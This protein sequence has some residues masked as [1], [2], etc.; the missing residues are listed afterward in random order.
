MPDKT[1]KK[2]SITIF[3]SPSCRL[4]GA[5]FLIMLAAKCFGFYPD[6]SWWIVTCPL[7]ITFAICGAFFVFFYAM[8]VVAL[9]VIIPIAIVSVILESVVGLF[10]DLFRK[11]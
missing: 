3:K 8:A 7:W 6:L 5:A 10:E 4:L 2:T 9:G 11:K 1:E